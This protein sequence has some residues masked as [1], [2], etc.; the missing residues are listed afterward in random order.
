[1]RLKLLTCVVMVLI[2]ICSTATA[3]TNETN[4]KLPTD[5]TI[6]TVVPE[7]STK[8]EESEP[9]SETTAPCMNNKS[10]ILREIALAKASGF[11]IEYS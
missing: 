3:C 6:D 5:T 4:D 11:L 7:E 1:M 9:Q 2:L 8:P 10:K